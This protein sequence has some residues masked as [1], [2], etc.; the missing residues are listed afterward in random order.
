MRLIRQ[1]GH[2][3]DPG[4]S[5][6]VEFKRSGQAMRIPGKPRALFAG[7]VQIWP[8]PPTPEAIKPI[9]KELSFVAKVCG[10]NTRDSKPWRA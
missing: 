4:H 8:P 1:P 10:N 7:P 6:R 9:L 5:D 2:E 3:I